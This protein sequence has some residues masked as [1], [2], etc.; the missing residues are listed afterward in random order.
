MQIFD[1][2]GLRLGEEKFDVQ[3]GETRIPV[4]APV[5]PGMY[6]LW[7]RNGSGSIHQKIKMIKL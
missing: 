4:S 5:Q 1:A 3:A 6:M 7:L 2:T